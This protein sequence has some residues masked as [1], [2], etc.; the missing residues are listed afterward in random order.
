MLLTRSERWVNFMSETPYVGFEISIYLR[1]ATTPSAS[2]VKLGWCCSQAEEKLQWGLFF[3]V[4]RDPSPEFVG[5]FHKKLVRGVWHCHSDSLKTIWTLWDH[6][7][8]KMQKTGIVTGV[9]R[10]LEGFCEAT[11]LLITTVVLQRA[12]SGLFDHAGDEGSDARRGGDERRGS[13]PRPPSLSGII[14]LSRAQLA[15]IS[16]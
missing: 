7:F 14:H 3:Y 15:L 9:R 10:N 8:L 6:L 16:E 13:E 5:R 2:V 12:P 1:I 11:L 4:S